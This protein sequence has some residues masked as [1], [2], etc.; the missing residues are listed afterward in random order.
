[1]PVLKV[2][3]VDVVAEPVFVLDPVA[4]LAGVTAISSTSASMQVGQACILEI[5]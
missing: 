5:G 4:L 3:A 1:M 2:T